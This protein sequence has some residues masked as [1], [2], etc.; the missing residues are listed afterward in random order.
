MVEDKYLFRVP[1]MDAKQH[2]VGYRFGWQQPAGAQVD[3]RRDNV[4][5]LAVVAKWLTA[6]ESGLCF[7]DAC[8][9]SVRSAHLEDVSPANIVLVLHSSLLQDSANT[10][11]LFSLQKRGFGL[12]LRGASLEFIAQNEPLLPCIGYFLLDY[13]DQAFTEIVKLL[14]YR[15]PAAFVVAE[16]VPDWAAFDVC[17]SQNSLSFFEN[18]CCT[19]RSNLALKKLSSGAQ[20]IVQ[21]MQMVRENVDIRHL[22]KVLQSDATLS[23]QLL[24]YINSASFGLSVE[25]QSL[26][27]AVAMLG[28]TPL[29][30]WL[31]LMLA[32]TSLDGFSPALLKVSIVRG[33]F[34]ELLARDFFSKDE[35][36]NLFLVGMFSRL[37][38]LLGIPIEQVLKD[39][40]LPE[41]VNQAL[42]TRSGI[43]GPF[44]ALAEVSE[45][46]SGA[47]A[48]LAAS[49][50]ITPER[51]NQAHLSAL[52]WARRLEF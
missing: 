20:Q 12:A 26:K 37:D 36:E 17:A 2:V 44:L 31:T 10:A 40:M 3:V 51:V 28:Y 6:I 52:V 29:F 49:L 33:R 11:L 25:I 35:A 27:H 13:D 47:A 22:E 42:I 34:A 4:Q 21:L 24:R 30:R 16:K 32:R 39:V 43:Y 46:Q 18:L 19:P 14:N 8:P 38:H 45:R 48:D 50:L 41:P 1:L 9:S 7:L 23:F 5:L 15:Q